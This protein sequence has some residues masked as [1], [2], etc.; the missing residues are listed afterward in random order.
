MHN[1]LSDHLRKA[2]SLI[3]TQSRAYRDA[4]TDRKDAGEARQWEGVRNTAAAAIA[5]LCVELQSPDNCD[6]VQA[7]NG[8]RV[9]RTCQTAWLREADGW[10]SFDWHGKFPWE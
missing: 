6:L 2:L 4:A 5:D 3:A 7:D 1:Y 9:C 8:A 10:H